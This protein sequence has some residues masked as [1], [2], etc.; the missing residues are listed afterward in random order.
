VPSFYEFAKHNTTA[1]AKRARDLLPHEFHRNVSFILH[2]QLSALICS[3]AQRT[4][5]WQV[6]APNP[7]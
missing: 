5:W 1:K 4:N 6:P 3:T 2:S 7:P